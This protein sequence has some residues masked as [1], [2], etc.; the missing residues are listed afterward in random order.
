MIVVK[1]KADG[2]EG[3]SGL[4]IFDPQDMEWQGNMSVDVPVRWEHAS[5]VLGNNLY[6][7]GGKTQ[8]VSK[9]RGFALTHFQFIYI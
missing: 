5:A 2:S 4:G 7:F 9:M 6:I 3:V 1:G 8:T